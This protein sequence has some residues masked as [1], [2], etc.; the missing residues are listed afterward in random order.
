[1]LRPLLIC[2]SYQNPFLMQKRLTQS[3]SCQWSPAR[4]SYTRNTS[5]GMV[6]MTGVWWLSSHRLPRVLD[7]ALCT[8]HLERG[9]FSLKTQLQASPLLV[10]NLCHI[11]LPVVVGK[12][13]NKSQAETAAMKQK[14]LQMPRLALVGQDP[15]SRLGDLL[16]LRV[17]CSHT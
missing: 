9:E 10:I 6:G 4:G 1:M 15:V 13:K 17:L 8:P 7:L 16:L 12:P 3:R 5:P 2:L 11:A 14:G